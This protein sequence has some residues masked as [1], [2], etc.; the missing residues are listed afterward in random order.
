MWPQGPSLVPIPAELPDISA[1]DPADLPKAVRD[2]CASSVELCCSPCLNAT[3]V[4]FAAPTTSPAKQH[5]QP[6][7]RS[8]QDTTHPPQLVLAGGSGGAVALEQLELTVLHSAGPGA[9][10]LREHG[11]HSQER[12]KRFH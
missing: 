3:P 2:G 11:E 5:L 7:V 4:S 10:L 6:T 8:G 1:L 12:G 9:E